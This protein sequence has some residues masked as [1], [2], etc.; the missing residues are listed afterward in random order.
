M[1]MTKKPILAPAGKHQLD[2][3]E[4]DEVDEISGDEQLCR[5][6]CDA[7][8]DYEWHWLERNR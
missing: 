3:S 6:W 7:H 2:L 1:A 4:I 5:V 8:Q